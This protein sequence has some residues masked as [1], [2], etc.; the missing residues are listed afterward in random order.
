V[1]VAKKAVDSTIRKV[2][3]YTA[4]I[5]MAII[6]LVLVCLPLAFAIPLWF[7]WVLFGTQSA[8]L[9]LNPLTLFGAG[10]AVWVTA[11]LGLIGIILAYPYMMKMISDEKSEDVQSEEEEEEE[12]ILEDALLEEI[13]EEDSMTSLE[14]DTD[15]DEEDAESED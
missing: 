1:S 7:Q 14:D 13:D 8:D 2:L 9:W 10:G 6:L 15:M 3:V 11:F 5:I 12:A 4:E